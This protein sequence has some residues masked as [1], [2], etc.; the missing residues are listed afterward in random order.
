MAAGRRLRL[1]VS[2]TRSGESVQAAVRLI[3]ID[4][5][6]MLATLPSTANALVLTTDL[7]G[8]IAVCQMAGDVTQTAYALLSDLVTIGRRAAAEA[9]T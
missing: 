9:A 3:E 8:E 5:R 6:E 1:V 4:E 7:L 2:G